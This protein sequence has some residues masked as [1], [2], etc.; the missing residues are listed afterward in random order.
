MTPYT[1]YVPSFPSMGPTASQFNYVPPT[2]SL[3][4]ILG[5]LHGT[6][7]TFGMPWAPGYTAAPSIGTPMRPTAPTAPVSPIPPGPTLD[8]A[9]AARLAMQNRARSMLNMPA[10]TPGTPQYQQWMMNYN[11]QQAL[12]GMWSPAERSGGGMGGG[13]G[14]AGR[15]VSSGGGGGFD[16]GFGGGDVGAGSHGGRPAY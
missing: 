4:T 10:I 1:P 7:S 8:P 15:G 3:E 14:G 13:M 2:Q 16:G 9:M 11:K 6:G 12:R 5:G